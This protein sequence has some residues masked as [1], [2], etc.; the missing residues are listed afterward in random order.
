MKT[1]PIFSLIKDADDAAAGQRAW[2]ERLRH[3]PHVDDLMAP[4]NLIAWRA[5]E[6]VARAKPRT[7]AGRR[8]KR[9]FLASVAV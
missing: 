2:V 5:E 4:I 9:E 6:D 3:D 7:A 8:A 1:D